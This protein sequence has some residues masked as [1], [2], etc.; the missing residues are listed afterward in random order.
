MDKKEVVYE[1]E[2]RMCEAH[3]TDVAVLK[4]LVESVEKNFPAWPPDKR[5][6]LVIIW[7]EK[8]WKEEMAL[9][10]QRDKKDNMK[11]FRK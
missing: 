6:D 8:L 3:K 5:C 9:Q 1:T 7:F 4:S 11:S 10:I 2:C